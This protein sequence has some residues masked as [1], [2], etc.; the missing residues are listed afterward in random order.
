MSIAKIIQTLKHHN[1]KEVKGMPT[2]IRGFS[3]TAGNPTIWCEVFT[4]KPWP[5]LWIVG[6]KAL[7]TTRYPGGKVLESAEQLREYL[8]PIRK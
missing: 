4:D 2:G 5:Y 8:E 7:D 6:N 1:F 3:Y